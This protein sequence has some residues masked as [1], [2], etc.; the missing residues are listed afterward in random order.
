MKRITAARKAVRAIAQLDELL[1]DLRPLDS[2]AHPDTRAGRAWAQLVGSVAR[3][4]LRADDVL[5]VE[6]PLNVKGAWIQGKREKYWAREVQEPPKP[7]PCWGELA[8][9]LT[10]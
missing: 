2:E 10:G 1:D 6:T 4:G 3:A 9:A 5:D 8:G 7:A